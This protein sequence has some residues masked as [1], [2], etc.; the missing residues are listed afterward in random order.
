[1]DVDFQQEDRSTS[2]GC[3]AH[4]SDGWFMTAHD[5][6]THTMETWPYVV[7]WRRGFRSS[8][9]N[10][11]HSYQRMWVCDFWIR[12]SNGGGIFKRQASW[13]F[14]FFIVS[15]IIYELGLH[16]NFEVKIIRRQTN[17][18]THTLHGWHVLGLVTVFFFRFSLL[19][20]NIC[21]LMISV[22]S[23]SLKKIT[24]VCF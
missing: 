10:Q 6:H 12:F 4:D 8:W 17:M 9:S 21:L 22:T 24:R 5:T 14:W 15:Y 11:V 23:V 19:V 3:C 18:T 13:S 1:M 16:F 20:L 7:A 2:F